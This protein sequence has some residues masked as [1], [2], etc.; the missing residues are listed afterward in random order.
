MHKV[1]GEIASNTTFSGVGATT[2]GGFTF[3]LGFL[4]VFRS[5]QA[6]SRWWEGGTILQQLRGE[7]FN[8][9][10]SMMAFC[11]GS[12]EKAQEVLKFQ[13]QLARLI[14]LLFAS[15]LCQV[16]TMDRKELELIALDGFDEESLSFLKETHDQS[17]VV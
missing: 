12:P 16:S 1:F 11:N 4:I 7:W 5:Q 6:F 13:H 14:S 15:G 17:E 8:A 9:Y 10:S 2:L 3:I